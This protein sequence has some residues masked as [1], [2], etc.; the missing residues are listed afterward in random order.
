MS[1]DPERH[2]LTHTHSHARTHAGP[3]AAPPAPPRTFTPR[4]GP[5][6][7]RARCQVPADGFPLTQRAEFGGQDK[8]R[9]Q[10]L[11]T[12]PLRLSPH[13]AARPGEGDGE[14]VPGALTAPAAECA[15]ERPAGPAPPRRQ[16]RRG[17]GRRAG[18]EGDTREAGRAA[19]PRRRPG[20]SP[21]PRA[22]GA[23]ARAAGRGSSLGNLAFPALCP[24]GEPEGATPTWGRPR[25]SP[26]PFP[27]FKGAR[28][29]PRAVPLKG[30]A[31]VQQEFTMPMPGLCVQELFL[32]LPEGVQSDLKPTS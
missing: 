16:G 23:G 11:P 13:S 26:H 5:P 24:R 31:Q 12:T 2:T 3:S 8:E 18:R 30:V 21:A 29:T 19:P 4:S 1:V 17:R 20:G 32:T 7:S 15:R 14:R 25:G 28:K 9:Q 6:G 10:G 27:A 22:A